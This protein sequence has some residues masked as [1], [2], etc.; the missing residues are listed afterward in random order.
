[1][2]VDLDITC[3]VADVGVTVEQG[4]GAAEVGEGRGIVDEE[5]ECNVIVSEV[6]VAD[7]G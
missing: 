7:R 5:E 3:E 1:V 4:V 2:A 6:N